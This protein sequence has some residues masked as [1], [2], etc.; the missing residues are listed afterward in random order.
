LH[1]ARFCYRYLLEPKYKLGFERP[2]ISSSQ[3]VE[4]LK[5][6][7]DVS[8][9]GRAILE[10]AL[11]LR[12]RFVCFPSH[13]V[14][15]MFA[16]VEILQKTCEVCFISSADFVA[17]TDPAGATM[18]TMPKEGC[19]GWEV[20]AAVMNVYPDEEFEQLANRREYES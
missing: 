13:L 20:V 5:N 9:E 12:K 11:A 6:N 14:R 17:I 4:I 15:Q 1:K 3:L 7:S 16:Q 18:A 8:P 19:P 2:K 10:S